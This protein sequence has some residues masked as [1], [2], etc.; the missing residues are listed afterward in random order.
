ME[1]V[2]VEQKEASEGIPS[3]AKSFAEWRK[4]QSF[5]TRKIAETA[6]MVERDM[7]HI[8]LMGDKVTP[9]VVKNAA[10]YRANFASML[11]AS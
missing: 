10:A 4:A 3:D 7:R 8:E 2:K 9:E 11:A 6:F 1:M 5:A